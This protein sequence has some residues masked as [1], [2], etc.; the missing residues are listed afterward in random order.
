MKINRNPTAIHPPLAAYSH[1]IELGGKQRWLVMSGQI[2]MEKDGTLPADPIEQFKLA[3]ANID[4]NLKAADMGTADLVKL[5]IYLAAEMDAE[6]RRA[7]LSSWLDGHKPTMTL[8]Y[9]AAL[10][11]PEIKVEIEALAC[12][13]RG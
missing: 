10:A 13:E 2:G 3:L 7:L 12:T 8:L 11:S 5:T 6:E 1:Q 9:V 4:H